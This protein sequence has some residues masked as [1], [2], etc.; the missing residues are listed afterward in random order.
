[1]MDGESAFREGS[2]TVC[3]MTW[4]LLDSCLDS[5]LLEAGGMKLVAELDWS[6]LVTEPLGLI[7]AMPKICSYWTYSL[8]RGT[9]EGYLKL[10]SADA[11]SA[12]D[13]ELI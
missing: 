10:L 9:N 7:S 12:S 13:T 6:R 4:F 5:C 3:S 2:S 8:V 11:D 1:M